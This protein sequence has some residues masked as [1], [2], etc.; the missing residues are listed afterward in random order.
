M[1]RFGCIAPSVIQL[2]W[3]LHKLLPSGVQANVVTLNVRNGLP[4]EQERALA[5][6]RGASDVLIDEGAAAITM[7]G[8]PVAARRGFA[9]EHAALEAL[10]ADRGAVPILSS[11]AASVLAFQRLAVKHPLLIT[12]YNDEVNAKIMAY[13][14]DAGLPAVGAIGLGATNAA[15]VNALTPSDFRALARQAL[16]RHPSADGIFLSARGNLLELSLEL[17]V[18]LGLPV[19][20][21]I[22]A[23]TW[24]SLSQL[25]VA[26]A[27]GGG[28]LLSS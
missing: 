12:Q 24:W 20:D 7:L 8:V 16:D 11:L 2:P 1:K 23:T 5:S 13:M 28:R 27:P 4:G 9:A 22:Q 17:E 18:A 10:T 14:R 6:L 26:A 19:T 21:Q 25:G 15:Q 3:D